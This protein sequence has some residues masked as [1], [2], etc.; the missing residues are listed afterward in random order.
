MSKTYLRN[1]EIAD[2]MQEIEA[3]FFAKGK[4]LRATRYEVV[5]TYQGEIQVGTITTTLSLDAYVKEHGMILCSFVN[6][7]PAP[8]DA[9]VGHELL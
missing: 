2:F 9:Q 4:T 3:R 8:I 7:G 6:S 5:V 1:P